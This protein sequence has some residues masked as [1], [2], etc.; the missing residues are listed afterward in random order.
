MEDKITGKELLAAIRTANRLSY[1]YQKRILEFISYFKMK[2]RLDENQIAAR[3]HDS[4]AFS[5]TKA[6]TN[7]YPKANLKV[8]T[9]MWPW[10]YIYTNLMEYYLGWTNRKTMSFCLSFVQMTDTGYYES[11]DNKRSWTAIHKYADVENSNSYGFFILKCSESKINNIEPTWDVDK[12]NM[13]KWVQ[14]TEDLVDYN[15]VKKSTFLVFRFKIEDIINQKT[16]NDVLLRF[17]N[18]VKQKTKIDLITPIE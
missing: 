14:S 7:D 11:L 5:K 18:I 9:N 13:E 17:S 8:W 3:K 6:H 12:K 10:D 16:T 2:F 1:E 15:V 4:D